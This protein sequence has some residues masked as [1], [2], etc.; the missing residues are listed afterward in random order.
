MVEMTNLMSDSRVPLLFNLNIHLTR[1]VVLYY[2]VDVA[3]NPV[4]RTFTLMAS[5]L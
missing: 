4:S 5:N 1:K 2:E 3:K